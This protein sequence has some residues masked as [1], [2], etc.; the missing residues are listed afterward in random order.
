MGQGILEGAD[1]AF[2]GYLKMAT[3]LKREND[4]KRGGAEEGILG[5]IIMW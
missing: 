3:H 4:K 2:C 5:E 1:E